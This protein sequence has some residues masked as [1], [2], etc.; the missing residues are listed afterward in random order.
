MALH[1]IDVE[2]PVAQ[3]PALAERRD[4]MVAQLDRAGLTLQTLYLDLLRLRMSDSGSAADTLATAT[5][6]ASALSRDIGYVLGAADELRSID[7]TG[8]PK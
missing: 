1:R 3:Q 8:R 7:S 4:E 6:Q 5:E 2:M